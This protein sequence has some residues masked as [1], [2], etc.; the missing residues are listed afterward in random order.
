MLKIGSL[1]A[2]LLGI[3]YY[4]YCKYK[5]YIY[6]YLNWSLSTQ[7]ERTAFQIVNLIL[8]VSN[9]HSRWQSLNL[10]VKL[11]HWEHS[12]SS[13]RSCTGGKILSIEF[14]YKMIT[15]HLTFTP[16]QDEVSEDAA[17]EEIILFYHEWLWLDCSYWKGKIVC[18]VKHS[19]APIS[20]VSREYFK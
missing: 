2:K 9:W 17:Q 5:L 1:D 19:I 13:I 20:T 11:S 12:S 14:I 18:S 6:I 16:P 8:T 3:V 15:P 7:A 10:T 4:L